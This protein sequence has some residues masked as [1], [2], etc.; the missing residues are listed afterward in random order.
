MQSENTA[1]PR[2]EMWTLQSVNIAVSPHTSWL[3]HFHR[4]VPLT[5]L[6][7]AVWEVPDAVDL[8]RPL[9]LLSCMM[10]LA[11]STPMATKPHAVCS[12]LHS[13]SLTLVLTRVLLHAMGSCLSSTRF[14]LLCQTSHP[15]ARYEISPSL[16]RLYHDFR[17]PSGCCAN[18]GRS[19]SATSHSSPK[20]LD[21]PCRK[22]LNI[23]I[24]CWVGLSL[25]LEHCFRLHSVKDWARLA[26]VW[27][28]SCSIRHSPPTLIW[29]I[30]Q[31]IQVQ[32]PL[33][34]EAYSAEREWQTP[35]D[36]SEPDEPYEEQHYQSPPQETYENPRCQRREPLKRRPGACIP[37]QQ[38]KTR[39]SL[40]RRS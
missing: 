26:H 1:G 31:M 2:H 7:L 19:D 13:N 3:T 14:S 32:R 25:L 6:D 29:T 21:D 11:S 27:E 17:E 38:A 33:F 15:H 18:W 40:R 35:E 39:V 37:C 20:T 4:L 34:H 9:T 5:S 16:A 28:S 8:Q 10:N 22:R 12:T 30:F 24:L 36:M 23:C